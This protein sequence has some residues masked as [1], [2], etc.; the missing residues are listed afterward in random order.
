[1]KKRR[2]LVYFLLVIAVP[3]LLELF[4]RPI[5]ICYLRMSRGIDRETALVEYW[6]K[7]PY[8][9][10]IPKSN[11]SGYHKYSNFKMNN[12]GFRN[13]YDITKEKGKNIYRIIVLGGS[14]AWGTAASS[15]ETVWTQV[16]ENLLKKDTHNNYQV[17][18]AGCSGY[19]S[20]QELMYL[21]FKLLQFC[22]DLIIVFDGYNDLF[23]SSLFPEQNYQYNICN[24]YEEEKEFFDNPVWKKMLQIILNDSSFYQLARII[25]AKIIYEKSLPIRKMYYHTKGIENYFYNI[26]STSNILKGRGIKSLF[27][28]QPYLGLSGKSFSG[29]E[30]KMLLKIAKERPYLVKLM[31]RLES[32][33]IKFAK[34]ND[35]V[36]YNTNKLFN[37]LSSQKTVWHDHIH[38]NDLG[39]RILAQSIYAFL[40]DRNL[41][42]KE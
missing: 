7:D 14:A 9:L 23:F 24:N 42:S 21:Q 32:E 22:P 30:Q 26:K 15:N 20:F 1:M 4:S 36:Y 39:Q 28:L 34:D 27:I 6:E 41:L 40:I 8:L 5:L 31:H 16:L 38:L 19:N 29:E 13:S 12:F 3:I 37:S 11:V 10:W 25:R 33:Y 2:L 35:I 18:N 17:L